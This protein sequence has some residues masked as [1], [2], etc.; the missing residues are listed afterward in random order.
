MKLFNSLGREL[1]EF[2]P[3]QAGEVK[4]YSCGP[5]VYD[6][7]HIGN[8]SA[9]IYWDILVRALQYKGFKVKR[10]INITDVGHLISD[11]D[12]GEDKLEKGA[13]RE[14]KSA[15]EI[16]Q[17]YT[18]DFLKNF[19]S[20]GLIEPTLFA[21]ASDYIADQQKIIKI[22]LEKGIAYKTKQA[23]YFDIRQL[24]DYNQLSGQKLSDKEVGARPEVITD[25]EKRNPQD[26]ALW[27]FTNGRFA[28]HELHWDSEWGEG[29]PGW[30][31][32][33][34]AIIHKELGEPIDI[35][36]G[37]IEHIGTHHPNEIAQTE[38]AYGPLSRFWLHNN[39]LMTDGK[40]ISKSSGTFITLSDLA[41][42]RFSAMDFKVLV[43]QS[44]YRSQSNFT[45]DALEAAQNLYREWLAWADSALQKTGKKIS[46]EEI[47]KFQIDLAIALEND[48]DTVQALAIINQ[49]VGQ[50]SPTNELLAFIE[51]MLGVKLTNRV[52]ITKDQQEMIAA[53]EE[54][55][56][57]K[58][59]ENADLLRN[60][61]SKQGIELNDTSDG[62][63][64]YRA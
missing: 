63:I 57:N 24:E 64:W 46:S 16:A 20:L 49:F 60:Q 29:F 47:K 61:L 27:F 7:Q 10:I 40:K 15:K 17:F 44:H 51:D 59:W 5:T 58:D 50:A 37:G 2:T 9:Y 4:I 19:R 13:R 28:D 53:R 43:L 21:K 11:G 25:S 62:P 52:D 38:E 42:K 41:K 55:R 26:F 23:I 3:L 32:E 54:A 8:Y 39:H 1:Q 30:H 36:T 6:Y 45:W 35:H 56:H 34:S 33:C 12:E 22:L 31:I 18:A 14:G 48:L